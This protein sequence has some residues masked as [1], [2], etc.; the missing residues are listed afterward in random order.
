MT[1]CFRVCIS[2]VR[3]DG[4][5]VRIPSMLSILEITHLTIDKCY[6]S[7]LFCQATLKELQDQFGEKR[8]AFVACDVTD[9]EQ[10]TR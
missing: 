1:M 3:E 10:F 7:F 5:Q 4:G 8:V 2:D 9:Q 6:C